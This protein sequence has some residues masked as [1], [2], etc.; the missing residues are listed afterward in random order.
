[1]KCM[2]KEPGKRFASVADL[3]ESLAKVTAQAA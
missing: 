2:E 3:Y 1:M